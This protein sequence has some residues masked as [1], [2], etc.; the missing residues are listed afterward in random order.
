MGLFDKIF[1]K[2]ENFGYKAA[3]T[4]HK[5]VVSGLVIGSVYG[6]YSLLRDYRA[7]FKSRK[8][9]EYSEK[10]QKREEII[11]KIIESQEHNKN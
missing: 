4:T 7:Y 8:T 1:T 5:I 10:L 2:I 3:N 11:R 9:D 6:F